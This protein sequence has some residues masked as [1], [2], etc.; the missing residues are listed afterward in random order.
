ME[1]KRFEIDVKFDDVTASVEERTSFF[2]TLETLDAL[3]IGHDKTRTS[4]ISLK[5]RE[6]PRRRQLK[7]LLQDIPLLRIR[8][9]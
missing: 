1:T 2:H 9:I 6:R 5:S 8:K 7:T 4:T 3:G